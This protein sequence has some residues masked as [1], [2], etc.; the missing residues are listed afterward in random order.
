MLMGCHLGDDIS[1]RVAG[2][3][4][5]PAVQRVS[6]VEEGTAQEKESV[7]APPREREPG[8]ECL[9][10]LPE[11]LVRAGAGN[12]TIALAREMINAGEAEL[13]QART[14]L[15]PTLTTGANIRFHNGRLQNA[16]GR[17]R[18]SFLGSL[19]YGAGAGARG[20][21]SPVV[22]GVRIF[23]HLGDALFSPAVAEF[24][25]SQRV[26]QAQATN[27]QILLDVGTAYLRLAETQGRI[28]AMRQTLKELDEVVR[29]TS[30]FAKTGQGRHGD[31][32]RVQSERHLSHVE[33]VRIEE[34][35]AVA[36]AVLAEL[37]SG[38]PASRLRTLDAAP[39]I[40]EV[41]DP[42]VPLECLLQQ[43][44]A[45]HP[46][47]AA[48]RM[49]VAA[50]ETRL[51][52]ERWRP[53]LPTM[54]V[55]FSAGLYGGGGTDV[56]YRFSRFGDRTDLDV[57]AVWTLQN[58]GFGNLALQN[59]TRADILLAEAHR[60][61]VVYLIERRV[62]EAH[63]LIRAKRE[64]LALAQRRLE[65]ASLAYQQDLKR[66]EN[67]EGRPIEV[68]NSVNLLAS[69]RQDYVRALAAYS[70][71]QLQMLTA[72]GQSVESK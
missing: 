25:L 67:L 71:A 16:N 52:Q 38:D 54:S 6:A 7:A 2:C 31:A 24:R 14:L 64:E 40:L 50:A 13:L 49:A 10:A 11:A 72:L 5:P 17:I 35:N 44:K 15:L 21:G 53:L 51:R 48:A 28:D 57:L 59:R 9:V 27:N 1:R 36:S 56:P 19:Y 65:N 61:R 37:L 58:A 4:T 60:R 8:T 63:A 34:E 68:M 42:T 30:H 29:V 45:Q 41:I 43:A 12:P 18:D 69:A 22:P 20:S 47:I 46:E 70:L 23:A 26:F 66:T 3:S 33:L 62:S 39:P 55:G 32:H